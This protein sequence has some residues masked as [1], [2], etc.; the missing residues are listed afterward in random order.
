MQPSGRVPVCDH[1]PGSPV[2]CSAKGSSSISHALTWQPGG[3]GLS[4][5]GGSGALCHSCHVFNCSLPHCVCPC[6]RWESPASLLGKVKHLNTVRI[7]GFGQTGFNFVRRDNEGINV[8]IYSPQSGPNRPALPDVCRAEG[9][10]G[11]LDQIMP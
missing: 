8:S 7:T 2:L 3:L 9:N 1:H 4:C 11:T 10:T 6:H 5:R